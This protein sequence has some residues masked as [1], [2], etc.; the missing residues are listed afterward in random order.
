MACHERIS[1]RPIDGKVGDG[2][3]SS[4]FNNKMFNLYNTSNKSGRA[5]AD[6]AHGNTDLACFLARQ[7]EQDHRAYVQLKRK[8]GGGSVHT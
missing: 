1:T 7:R 2:L 4:W 3:G 5:D 6:K 8:V